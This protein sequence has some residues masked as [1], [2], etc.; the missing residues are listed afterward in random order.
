M[1]NERADSL[2]VKMRPSHIALGSGRDPGSNPGRRIKFCFCS[3]HTQ[4]RHTYTYIDLVKRRQG[5]DSGLLTERSILAMD[6]AR[7]ICDHP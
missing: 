1:T 2:V 5:S 4:Q 7:M 6:Y 3:R